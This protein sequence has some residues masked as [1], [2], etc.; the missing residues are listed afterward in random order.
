MLLHLLK[1]TGRSMKHIHQ[2][3]AQFA[4]PTEPNRQAALKRRQKQAN[5]RLQELRKRSKGLHGSQQPLQ[6][7]AA[8]IIPISSSS[9]K[10]LSL[11]E[12][13]ESGGGAG[14]PRQRRRLVV[15]E[16]DPQGEEDLID[17]TPPEPAVGD[18]RTVAEDGG[19]V[20]SAPP[21]L[22]GSAEDV[23]SGVEQGLGE[24]QPDPELESGPLASGDAL[25]HEPEMAAHE[26]DLPRS[27]RR[28][29]ARP[30]EVDRLR[31]YAWDKC[32]SPF[33]ET[34]H[35][36]TVC[37]LRQ[38]IIIYR[39]IEQHPINKEKFGCIDTSASRQR[40]A[41][42]RYV[43]EDGRPDD[44]PKRPS[45]LGGR[46]QDLQSTRCMEHG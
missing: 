33:S 26:H 16:S 41:P 20:D 45:G 23:A 29:R 24:A 18:M 19:I 10:G 3:K 1:L 6:Q 42:P 37:T 31:P 40:K 38:P 32:A 34:G 27:E 21:T 11:E 46:P 13:E 22:S 7:Q 43:P 8:L 44:S 35:L 9:N 30:R 12:S 15:P 5:E 2:P 39:R 25:V 4:S 14:H 36:C 17:G 28:P